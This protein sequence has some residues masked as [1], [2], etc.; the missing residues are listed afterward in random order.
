MNIQKGVKNNITNI[1]IIC[2]NVLLV[3][4][5]I[6]FITQSKIAIQIIKK[7]TITNFINTSK[8]THS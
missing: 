1:D 2:N 3:L 5:E 6:S 8:V 7:Y 4:L